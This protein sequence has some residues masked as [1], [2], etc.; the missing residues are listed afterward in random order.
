MREPPAD[1]TRD[2]VLTA[3]REHWDLDIDDAEHLPV[4]FGAHHWVASSGGRRAWFVTLDGLLPRHSAD[5]LEA[6]YAGAASLASRLDFVLSCLPR[7]SGEFTAPF[8]DG[9]LSV[10]PWLD[11]SSPSDGTWTDDDVRATTAMLDRLHATSVAGIPSWEPLLADP[12]V[13][14]DE[15]AASLAQPWDTGPYGE[16]ARQALDQQIGDVRRWAVRYDDLAAIALDHRDTWVPTHGEP[17]PSNQLVV[18]GHRFLVDWESLELAPR[19][20]DLWALGPGWE[21]S[22]SSSADPAMLELFDLQ[23]GLDE[24]GGYAT[25]FSRPHTGGESDQVAIQALLDELER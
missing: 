19:E 17:D 24:I 11:G 25:W 2:D 18:H 21:S 1:V 9:A 8:A 13:F 14:A 15:L 20:R 5:S 3:L 12:S 7:P 16:A 22:Y 10:A 4:G 23:W 6:A